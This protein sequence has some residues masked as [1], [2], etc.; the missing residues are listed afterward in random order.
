MKEDRII[1]RRPNARPA[2]FALKKQLRWIPAHYYLIQELARELTIE[3]GRQ[4][5]V[6]S[7][8]RAEVKK[9]LI[10]TGKLKK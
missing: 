4:I 6:S 8:I 2:E 10:R 5:S 3:S 7:L 1:I 9:L